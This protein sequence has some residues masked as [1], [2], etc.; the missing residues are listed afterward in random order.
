[1]ASIY[2]ERIAGLTS[3]DPALVEAWMRLE[4][5]T[6]D[7]LTPAQFESEVCMANVCIAEASPA[8]NAALARSY[9]L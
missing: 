4:H 2:Q 6:L 8:Q 5:G 9:G 3:H 7:H 1:M